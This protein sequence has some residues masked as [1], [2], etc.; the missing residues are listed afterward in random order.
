[1]DPTARSASSTKGCAFAK[2]SSASAFSP[3]ILSASNSHTSLIF[4]TASASFLASMELRSNLLNILFVDS[5][6][7][8]NLISSSAK[9]TFIFSTSFAPDANFSKPIS[10]RLALVRISPYFLAYITE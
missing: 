1:M 10:T 3:A 8:L 4:A 7:T 2:S 5:S 6:A 9:T